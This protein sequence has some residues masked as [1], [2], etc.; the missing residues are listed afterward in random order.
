PG[1]YRLDI[2]VRV[3]N[4]GDTAVDKVLGLWGPVGMTND[5]ARNSAEHTRVALYASTES[6][7]FVQFEDAP[8]VRSIPSEVKDIN[9]ELAE[10]GLETF[11][12]VDARKL[13]DVDQEDRFLVV[14]GFRTQYFL[15]FIA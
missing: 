4:Q 5:S 2:S 1:S 8:P 14:H 7:R 13:D 11:D 3:E 6:K 9:E 10:E 15:A 12:W